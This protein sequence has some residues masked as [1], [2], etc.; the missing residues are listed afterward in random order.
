MTYLVTNYDDQMIGG[1]SQ[2]ARCV[3]IFGR[4]NVNLKSVC[5]HKSFDNQKILMTYMN[6]GENHMFLPV[7]VFCK[8]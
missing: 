7:T 5:T 6:Y 2:W 4:Y 8:I 3:P 1:R